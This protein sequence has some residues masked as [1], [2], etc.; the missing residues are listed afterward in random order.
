MPLWFAGLVLAYVVAGWTL[1]DGPPLLFP[2]WVAPLLAGSAGV[3]AV[4]TARLS[5][6][7]WAE[8]RAQLDGNRVGQTMLVLLGTAAF[9]HAFMGWKAALP[10]WH[11]Y[12]YD[13]TLAALDARL[14]GTDPWRLLPPWLGLYQWAYVA[15]FPLVALTVTWMAWR[16]DWCYFVAF[17]LT[18]IV[19]GTV[20]A[21]LFPAAGPVFLHDLTGDPRY[22]PV[23][24]RLPPLMRQARESL[25]SLY[26]AGQPSSI[27]AFPSLHVA[28]A[29]LGTL[30]AWR[31]SRPVGVAVGAYTL[32][33]L[34]ASVGLGW[35]Y[36]VDG[37][38][39]LLL[40]PGLWWVAGRV[41]H[42][43]ARYPTR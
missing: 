14:H 10:A 40:V 32:L 31:V 27:S 16:R 30:A 33:L 6:A 24:E 41:A 3:G 37:E 4:L 29:W 11:P 28:I 8:A 18:W 42:P 35:H 9:L 1:P 43:K 19:L 20:L 2:L 38:A 13:L 15:W 39:A 21:G 23:V 17:A 7:P 36:A 5:H 25:W 22:L 12:A 34:A 26:A